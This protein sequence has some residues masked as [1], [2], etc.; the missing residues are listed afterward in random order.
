[1]M[2]ID[3]LR[4]VVSSGMSFRCSVPCRC[5]RRASAFAS[6]VARP[7]ARSPP[8]QTV[9]PER[10][11]PVAWP[12]LVGSPASRCAAPVGRGGRKRKRQARTEGK[13]K[14]RGTPWR[15]KPVCT[16]GG[17]ARAW[18]RQGAV[19]VRNVASALAKPRALLAG[20]RRP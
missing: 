17:A 13:I 14:G 5:A 10:A 7:P 3:S 2:S 4:V 11:M 15:E 6:H 1:M 12:A 20:L 9:C 19:T 16:W 8:V 18:V